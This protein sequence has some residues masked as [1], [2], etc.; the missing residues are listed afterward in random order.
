MTAK[1]IAD[2]ILAEPQIIIQH[3]GRFRRAILAR[4]LASGMAAGALRGLERTRHAP[5][6]GAAFLLV[7]R[8]TEIE[9]ERVVFGHLSSLFDSEQTL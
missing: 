4:F 8:H 1:A 3:I 2:M 7:R 6:T 9:I 5:P